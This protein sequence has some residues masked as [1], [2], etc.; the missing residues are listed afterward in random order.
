[1][2]LLDSTP[3]RPA[4]AIRRA[5]PPGGFTLIELLVVIAIIS[6]L[7]G[8]LLPAVQR[9]REV[10]EQQQKQCQ[11]MQCSNNLKQMTLALHT[12]QDTWQK[13]LG[14]IQRLMDNYRRKYG[15]LPEHEREQE[16]DAA[17]AAALK[18]SL[19]QLCAIQSQAQ[20]ILEGIDRLARGADENDRAVLLAARDPLRTIA[21]KTGPALDEAL[22]ELPWDRAEVCAAGP[23]RTARP[24]YNPY[25]TIDAPETPKPQGGDGVPDVITAPGQGGGQAGQIDLVGGEGEEAESPSRHPGG[26]QF[27]MGDGSVRLADGSVRLISPNV[28]SGKPL[29]VEVQ[30]GALQR[31]LNQAYREKTLFD[32]ILEGTDAQGKYFKHT[33]EKVIVTNVRPSMSDPQC[34]V[35]FLGGVPAGTPML[36]QEPEKPAP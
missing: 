36:E 26:A 6:T 1:M 2:N 20:N 32:G 29:V 10:A 16:V 7:I 19:G 9:V 22:K 23:Q 17:T 15:S 33:F 25:I 35:F 11:R 21:E 14:E 31:A 18:H 8:L 24:L 4:R 30:P 28:A 13:D 3:L 34:L 27:L 12:T 5:S